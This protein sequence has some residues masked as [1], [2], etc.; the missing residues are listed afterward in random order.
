MT[1]CAFN[2]GY[3]QVVE[4]QNA[5]ISKSYDVCLHPVDN[6]KVNKFFSNSC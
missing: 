6:C 2:N 4:M 3:L 1:Y 5:D